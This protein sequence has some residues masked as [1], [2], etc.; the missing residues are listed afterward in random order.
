MTEIGIVAGAI[1]I[2]LEEKNIP[3][4]VAEIKCLMDEPADLIDMSLGWL[5]RENYVRVI[6]GGEKYSALVPNMVSAIAI[7]ELQNV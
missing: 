2:L 6:R 4:S 5:I 1:L 3:V 7:E